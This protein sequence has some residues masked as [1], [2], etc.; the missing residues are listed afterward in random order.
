M[1]C[2]TNPA[3]SSSATP[4]A[5]SATNTP[6]MSAAGQPGGVSE[7]DR[8]LRPQRDRRRLRLTGRVEPAAADHQTGGQSDR[9]HQPLSFDDVRLRCSSQASPPLPGR[10][11]DRTRSGRAARRPAVD[12]GEDPRRVP[13]HDGAWPADR[14]AAT[15]SGVTLIPSAS[16]SAAASRRSASTRSATP[17]SM[18]LIRSSSRIARSPRGRARSRD[19]TQ[20]RANASSSSTP[21]SISLAIAPSTRSGR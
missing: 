18:P 16:G 9:D 5:S 12:A 8:F 10:S 6:S 13:G 4:V 19:S 15:R 1:T 3:G 11:R 2:R 7:L 20:A 21:S 17:R 14:S